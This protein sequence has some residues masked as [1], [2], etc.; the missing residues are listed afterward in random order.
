M[1]PHHRVSKPHTSHCAR[2]DE[3]SR[4]FWEERER[5]RGGGPGGGEVKEGGRLYAGRQA[6][7]QCAVPL[8]A[9]RPPLCLPVCLPVC[10]PRLQPRADKSCLGRSSCTL[11]PASSRGRKPDKNRPQKLLAASRFGLAVK[12]L[13]RLISRRTSVR[14]RFGSF[15]FRCSVYGLTQCLC[16]LLQS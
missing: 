5:G 6:G 16:L 14:F 4:F 1:P 11:S 9:I 12:E 3:H 15:L 10:L 8:G 13:L 7:N 2:V